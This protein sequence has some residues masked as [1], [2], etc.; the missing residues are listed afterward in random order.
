[1]IDVIC[2]DAV[3]IGDHRIVEEFL[4]F[5]EFFVEGNKDDWLISLKL[6]YKHEVK[7]VNKNHPKH[8]Q[9]VKLINMSMEHGIECKRHNLYKH[10]M[11]MLLYLFERLAD[12]NIVAAL[13]NQIEKRR[14]Q[15]PFEELSNVFLCFIISLPISIIVFIIELIYYKF[16]LCKIVKF[17]PYK[18]VC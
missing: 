5:R 1:M 3:F 6:D 8:K 18:I 17:K 14:N 16:K 15:I 10:G 2:G 9:I 4:N 7:I 13:R 12:Q 11:L